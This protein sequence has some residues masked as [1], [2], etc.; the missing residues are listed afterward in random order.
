MYKIKLYWGFHAPFDSKN[1]VLEIFVED[2]RTKLQYNYLHLCAKT[3]TS[4]YRVE[5]VHNVSEW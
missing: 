2:L 5:F 4:A 1:R 3:Q